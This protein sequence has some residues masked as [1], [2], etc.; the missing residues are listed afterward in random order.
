[1]PCE[2]ALR[3][4]VRKIK[5]L[6]MEIIAPQHGSVLNQKQDIRLVADALESLKGVGIDGLVQE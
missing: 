5:E 1:M 6:D 4:A 2:K 3:H